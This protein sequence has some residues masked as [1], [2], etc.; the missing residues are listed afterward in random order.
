MNEAIKKVIGNE[1]SGAVNAPSLLPEIL[2]II[3]HGS[4]ERR[5]SRL[6]REHGIE[7]DAA[8]KI[9]AQAMMPD[10]FTTR[11]RNDVSDLGR[12]MVDQDYTN[13]GRALRSHIRRQK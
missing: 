9:L 4:I 11:V 8:Y 5:I 1:G 3:E 2:K 6:F 12:N 10:W 7:P 13:L